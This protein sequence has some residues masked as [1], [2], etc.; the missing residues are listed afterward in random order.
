MK[1]VALAGVALVFL[2]AAVGAQTM[3]ILCEN[4]PPNQFTAADGTLG[5]F[6][7]EVVREIQKRVGN[8]DPIQLVP[9]ARGYDLIQR[10]PNV[11]LFQ[12]T[13]TADR[14]PIFKWVGPVMEEVFALYSKAGSPIHV[15]GL[16][17]A[18]KIGSIGVYLNDV[19]DL[20]LTKDG[21]K[22]LDRTDDPVINFKKLILGRVDLI[23][24]SPDSI[25]DLAK[26][27][28]YSISDVRMVYPFAKSQIFIAMSLGTGDDVVAKWND[29]LDAMK[30]DGSFSR[31]FKKYYPNLDLPGP[32][33]TTF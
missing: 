19:R 12:M 16:D 27:A 5:G 18:K 29:A 3:T 28:G 10:Q 32:A 14:N 17:D 24:A 13:R 8:T 23:A 11:V 9:W 4:D 20:I 33:I 22:N 30:K 7:I 25:A 26:S 2:C 1:R 15:A 21:F 6:T 31:I